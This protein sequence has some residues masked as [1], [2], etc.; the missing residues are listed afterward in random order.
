MVKFGTGHPT[1]TTK[2]YHTETISES[3]ILEGHAPTPLAGAFNMQ[4]A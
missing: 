1:L 4:D 2:W 3:L